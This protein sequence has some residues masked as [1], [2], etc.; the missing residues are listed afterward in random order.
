MMWKL[1]RFSLFCFL[2]IGFSFWANININD[3]S[4]RFCS[5]NS[6]KLDKHVSIYNKAWE[7][8]EECIVIINKSLNTGYID[9]HFVSQTQTNQW[10]KACWLPW[11]P[12]DAFVKYIK[13]SRSG[14]IFV[15]ANIEEEKS[16]ETD[17]PVWMQWVR[18]GCLA[19]FVVDKNKDEIAIDWSLLSMITRKASL[20]EVWVDDAK[21]FLNKIKFEKP[22]K[23]SRI[24][25]FW[26]WLKSQILFDNIN[27]EVNL[28]I[29]IKNIW[30]IGQKIALSWKLHSIFGYGKRLEIDNQILE[31]NKDLVLDTKKEWV[32]LSIPEYHW[33]FRFHLNLK[34]SPY[35]AFDSSRIPKEKMVWWFEKVN[36]I[37]FIVSWISIWFWTLLIFVLFMVYYVFKKKKVIKK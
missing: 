7:K 3:I 31:R 2:L 24:F 29:G 14:L 27:K 28:R 15:G 5:E 22:W 19:F 20:F 36:I 4:I 21:D 10:E 13:A 9:L 30:N 34:K 11:N 25:F 23:S 12:D 6:N 18:W 26:N 32:N 1:I 8:S 35:F 33:L 37:F 17:F 16:F